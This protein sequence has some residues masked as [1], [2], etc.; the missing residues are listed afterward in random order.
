MIE[1]QHKSNIRVLE[2]II[3]AYRKEFAKLKEVYYNLR[4]QFDQVLNQNKGLIHKRIKLKWNIKDYK[5][6]IIKLSI[7][8]T[9][10][11][12]GLLS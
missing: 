9:K 7:I 1:E 8:N 2:T 10:L 6:D 5:K 3:N 11:A 4:S 12:Q